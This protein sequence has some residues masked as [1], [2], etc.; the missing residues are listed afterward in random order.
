MKVNDM[1]KKQKQ[2]N[3]GLA[4]NYAEELKMI[5]SSLCE[6]IKNSQSMTEAWNKI[7]R[8]YREIEAL[9][10]KQKCTGSKSFSIL[11]DDVDGH[12]KYLQG[13]DLPIMVSTIWDDEND[14]MLSKVSEMHI[15]LVDGTQALLITPEL[16]SLP[17]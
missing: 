5:V 17:K 15:G 8:F 6:D 11:T 14:C 9:R 13:I 4:I 2:M 1:T 16:I 10:N 3:I 7:D 12:T